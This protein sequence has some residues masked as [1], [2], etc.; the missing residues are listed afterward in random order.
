ML[1]SA[2]FCASERNR[3]FLAHIVEPSLRGE[4]TK[5]VRALLLEGIRRAAGAKSVA[6]PLQRD[7]IAQ[8]A[9]G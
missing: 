3:R 7:D 4:L 6:A 8:S 1:A 9:R 2:D 5:G